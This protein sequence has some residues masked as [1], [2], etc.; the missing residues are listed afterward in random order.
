[1]LAILLSNRFGERMYSTVAPMMGLPLAR[2]AKR[3]R[4][5]DLKGASYLPGLNDWAFRASAENCTPYQNSMDGTR[6]VRTV[7]LYADKYLI[8]ESFSPD[9]RAWPSECELPV[10]KSWEQVHEYVLSVRR[11]RKYA[12]EAYSFDLVDTTG[13]LPDML[14]GSIPEAT[15]GVTATHIYCIML[16]VEK[17][18]I[19]HSLSL[20][21]HCTDSASNSLNALITLATPTEHLV[22]ELKVA[23]LG[24]QRT[25]YYLFAPFF[26]L[27]PS[28]AYPCWDHSG[29]TVL[30]NLT[31]SKRE[32]VAERI[33][34]TSTSLPTV[35]AASVRDLHNLKL[36][37]PASKIKF[38]DIS[39]YIRQNFVM[40]L[41]EFWHNQSSMSLLL[42]C[43]G[44]ELLNYT[45]RLRCGHTHH[46]ELMVSAPPLM[47][48]EVCGRGS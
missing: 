1:M 35:V 9:V 34:I 13:K 38:G 8:G 25:D 31:N 48:P 14:T 46:L 17:K 4:A 21:G 24:L 15:S 47:S 30:R 28:I 41:V 20:T 10:T 23:Y 18:A 37:H 32:I 11:Q 2:Q 29:R 43:R 3:L 44:L 45:F 22:K 39:P 16:E 27:Y 40:Q 42:M 33:D 19:K 36:L 5:K 12:A 6:V 26:R 7:E